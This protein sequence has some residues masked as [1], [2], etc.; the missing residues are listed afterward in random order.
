MSADRFKRAA[1]LNRSGSWNKYSYTLNDPVNRTDPTGQFA[2]VPE[3]PTVD[4]CLEFPNDENCLSEGPG[5]DGPI[6]TKGGGGTNPSSTG[7]TAWQYLTSIWS[8]CLND[9][10]QDADSRVSRSR[11]SSDSD[12]RSHRKSISILLG[13]RSP[14]SRDSDHFVAG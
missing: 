6:E 13:S 5:G 4:Y 3:T 8:N 14:F 7:P 11:F 12:H 9:F 2:R 10:K 1:K